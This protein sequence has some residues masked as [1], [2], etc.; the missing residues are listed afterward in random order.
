MASGDKNDP[1]PFTF[2]E[3]QA[4]LSL[5]LVMRLRR[6]PFKVV[7]SLYDIPYL[8]GYSKDG[9]TIYIDRDLAHWKGGLTRRF[10]I[11]HEDVEKTLIDAL[12][13]AQGAEL[14]ELLKLLR[15]KSKNDEIYFHC[16][17]VATAMEE[18]A[19]WLKSGK[20]GVDSY[21]AFMKTQ[22]KKAEDEH[23]LRVPADLDM[24]PYQGA[25]R[26]DVHLRRVMKAKMAA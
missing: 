12:A 16:H 7:A 18:H 17:G 19:V 9:K 11:L 8:A 3:A 22:V 23:I 5:P 2:K 15:M 13:A 21:N 24:T 10:L 6:R 1:I 25:D 26:E 14:A 20:R 4:V